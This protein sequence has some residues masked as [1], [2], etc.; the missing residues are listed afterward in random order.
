MGAH[1]RHLSRYSPDFN[2]IEG[3]G[4][5]VKGALRAAARTEDTRYRAIAEVPI[6]VTPNKATGW[7]EQCG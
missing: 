5:K 7:F 3:M 1:L 4:S 6:P 2:P